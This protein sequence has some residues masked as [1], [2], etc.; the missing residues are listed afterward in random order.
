MLGLRAHP[1][2]ERVEPLVGELVVRAGVGAARLLAGPQVAEPLEPLRLG[3]V[4]ALGGGL[5]DAS[6]PHHPHEV[7][8]ACAALA[9]EDEDGVRGRGE[10]ASLDKLRIGG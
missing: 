2:A 7:V 10:V 4:L 1:R 3:V 9:D 5:V 6:L 8:R